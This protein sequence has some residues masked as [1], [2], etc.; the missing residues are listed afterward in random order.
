MAQSP[1][2]VFYGPPDINDLRAPVPSK[3][4][5]VPQSSGHGV[6]EGGREGEGGGGREGGPTPY[7]TGTRFRQDE[8]GMPVHFL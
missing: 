2:G 7:R 6:T 1:N 3:P 5:K 4:L 8:G